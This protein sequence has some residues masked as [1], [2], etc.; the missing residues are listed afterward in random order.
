MLCSHYAY[1]PSRLVLARPPSRDLT[2]HGCRVRAYKDVLAACP[3]MVG[4]QGPH[5]KLAAS[6]ARRPH[7]TVGRRSSEKLSVV[8]CASDVEPMLHDRTRRIQH[9]SYHAYRP[10]R[11]VLARLPS[12]DLTRHGCRVRAYKDV[13]AACPAMVGG[14]R[15][16]SKPADHRFVFSRR[17]PCETATARDGTRAWMPRS[18]ARKARVASITLRGNAMRQHHTQPAALATC[19]GLLRHRVQARVAFADLPLPKVI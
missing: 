2:R 11:L 19:A 8:R 7:Q 10:S 16:C 5:S 14:Q 6:R 17:G 3:A 1:R 13:L 18:P 4:G 12:R 9:C 15:P